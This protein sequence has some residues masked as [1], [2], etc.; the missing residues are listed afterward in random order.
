MKALLT[1]EV[2]Q[3]LLPLLYIIPLDHVYYTLLLTLIQGRLKILT[4]FLGGVVVEMNL[5]LVIV[6]FGQLLLAIPS[7]LVR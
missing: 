2:L 6:A 1:N 4:V 7:R 5:F 3:L